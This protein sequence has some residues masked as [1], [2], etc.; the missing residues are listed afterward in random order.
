MVAQLLER[1]SAGIGIRQPSAPSADEWLGAE[2]HMPNLRRELRQRNT[3]VGGSA[4]A[5]MAGA[6]FM[7]GLAMG[8]FA[9]LLI[10]R[11]RRI[12]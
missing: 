4:G 3:P 1:N 8:S 10:I 9:A 12:L 5:W 6:L 2:S 11:S 7:A